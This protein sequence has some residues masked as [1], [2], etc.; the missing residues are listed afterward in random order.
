[1]V[2]LTV[3]HPNIEPETGAISSAMLY[4]DWSPAYSFLKCLIDIQRIMYAPVVTEPL[5]AANSIAAA[6]FIGDKE[7]Y[8]QTARWVVN[9][10]QISSL[11]ITCCCENKFCPFVQVMDGRART[12]R[13]ALRGTGDG[14]VRSLACSSTPFS[15]PSA[16][17]CSH[18]CIATSL[19][20][21][22]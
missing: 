1:M 22:R 5:E 19:L 15:S 13:A 16:F 2:C 20:F 11:F 6:I 10:I 8:D 21:R 18:P 17:P 3:W 12:Y 9:F 14:V 7:S 4:D